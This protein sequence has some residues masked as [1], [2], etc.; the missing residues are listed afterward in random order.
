MQGLDS[1]MVLRKE[2]ETE[3]IALDRWSKEPSDAPA[4]RPED[5]ELGSLH[6][7]PRGCVLSCTT[8]RPTPGDTSL[9][10]E[11]LAR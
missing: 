10:K 8:L 9:N 4:D 5:L 6:H 11:S 7:R 2:I 3:A 1:Q